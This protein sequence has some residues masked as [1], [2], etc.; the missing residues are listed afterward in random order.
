MSRPSEGF[1]LIAGPCSYFG[2]EVKKVG[3][4]CDEDHDGSVVDSLV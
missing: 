1:T 2:I 3:D 4:E